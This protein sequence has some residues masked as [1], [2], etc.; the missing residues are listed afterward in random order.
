VIDLNIVIFELMAFHMIFLV[1][2]IFSIISTDSYSTLF[3]LTFFLILLIPFYMVLNNFS[4]LILLNDLETFFLFK[5][6]LFYSNIISG[7][8]GLFLIIQLVYL[9]FNT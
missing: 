8:I 5:I 7:F 9:Q 3:S 2:F 4:E 1:L 6:L